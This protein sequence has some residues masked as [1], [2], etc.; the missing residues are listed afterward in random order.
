MN[1]I[2]DDILYYILIVRN[3]SSKK[4]T[5]HISFK[6]AFNVP[7]ITPPQLATNLAMFPQN[8]LFS[9]YKECNNHREL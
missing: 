8:L 7:N 1:H 9:N 3:T 6:Y 2:K 5:V 4:L